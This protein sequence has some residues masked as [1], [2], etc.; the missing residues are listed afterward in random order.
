MPVGFAIRKNTGTKA[1]LIINDNRLA[2]W[3]SPLLDLDISPLKR[4][5][6]TIL[7]V[8]HGSYHV[9]NYELFYDNIRANALQRAQEWRPTPN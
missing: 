5:Y 4:G 9:V 3:F 2:G 6:F 7:R 8:V 1:Y